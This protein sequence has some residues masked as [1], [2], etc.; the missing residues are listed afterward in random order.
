MAPY[1]SFIEIKEFEGSYVQGTTTRFSVPVCRKCADK[2]RLIIFLK[3][4]IFAGVALIGMFIGSIMDNPYAG[5][6]IGGVLGY[7]IGSFYKAETFPVKLTSMDI[8]FKNED[9]Q[10]LFEEANRGNMK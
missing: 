3:Y 2:I 4:A 8:T 6:A 7:F 9:Y 10:R 5:V 1:D